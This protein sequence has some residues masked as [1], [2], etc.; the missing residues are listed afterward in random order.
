MRRTIITITMCTQPNLEPGLC[1]KDLTYS[2]LSISMTGRR[3]EIEARVV[4]M[5]TCI[6]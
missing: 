1:Y 4:V 3:V 6:M 2:E 5:E